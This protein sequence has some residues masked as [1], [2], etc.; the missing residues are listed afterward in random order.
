MKHFAILTFRLWFEFASHI[1]SP[2]AIDAYLFH[3]FSEYSK[4][5]KFNIEDADIFVPAK[6][7]LKVKK[8]KDTV[9]Q[10]S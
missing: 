2:V 10:T 1:L 6:E 5:L 9:M 3:L 7:L 8:E 4:L